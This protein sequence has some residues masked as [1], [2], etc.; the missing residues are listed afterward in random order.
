MELKLVTNVLKANDAL[1]EQNRHLLSQKGL[2]TINIMSSPGSG[3]TSLLE[4]TIDALRDEVRIGVI[5][6]DIATSKDALRIRAKEVP[7]IQI[8]TS[9]GC[10]LDANM[11]QQAL[12]E[13]PLDGLD[14]LVIENVGNLV[15]PAGFDLGEDFKVML[16]SVTEGN[17]KPLKY[18]RMFLESRAVIINKI[19][20][21]P[22]TEFDMT[23]AERDIRSINPKAQLF[24]LS[25]RTGEGFEKWCAWLKARV[26]DKKAVL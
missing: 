1:A 6:G 5:E 26:A 17:D 20:L 15:C 3:K 25:A 19:D 11:I 9:G 21:L 10:H 22:Y 2:L 8:N 23:L 18:P 4:R 14:L 12:A 16:L 13:F 24:A 7:V